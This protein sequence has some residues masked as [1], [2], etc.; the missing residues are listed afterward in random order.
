M[1]VGEELMFSTGA[2]DAI[3]AHEMGEAGFNTLY[4]SGANATLTETPT[5]D[6]GGDLVSE[7]I[8]SI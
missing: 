7:M 5:F 3:M 8:R 2:A 4:C 6:C 1:S